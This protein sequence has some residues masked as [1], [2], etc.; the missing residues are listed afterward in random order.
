[1]DV[2]CNNVARSRNV[3]TS[4]AIPTA[5]THFN[6][7]QRSHGDLLLPGRTKNTEVFT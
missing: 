5:R 6:I 3:C 2:K 7:I 1:M 4:M